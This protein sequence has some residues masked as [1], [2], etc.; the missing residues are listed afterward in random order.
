MNIQCA[1]DEVVAAT[2][3]AHQ[4]GRRLRTAGVG[5]LPPV[6]HEGDG[7]AALRNKTGVGHAGLLPYAVIANRDPRAGDRTAAVPRGMR[8]M[9]A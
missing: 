7:G 1:A 6:P 4:P 2:P 5:T 8:A 9:A 3:A